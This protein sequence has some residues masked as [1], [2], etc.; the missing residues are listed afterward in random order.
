MEVN[1]YL[2]D[3]S[4]VSQELRGAIVG[5]A[6]ALRILEQHPFCTL[7]LKFIDLFVITSVCVALEDN[8]LR[9]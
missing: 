5:V 4:V 8:L 7:D 3:G 6:A 9:I 2:L 1:L